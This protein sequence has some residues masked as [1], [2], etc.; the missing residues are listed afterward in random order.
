MTAPLTRQRV[1]FHVELNEVTSEVV[2]ALG[3]LMDLFWYAAV[4]VTAWCIYFA[5]HVG[6]AQL[7]LVRGAGGATILALGLLPA[8]LAS[9]ISWLCLGTQFSSVSTHTL[10][11]V[12]APVCFIGFFGVYALAGLLVV[13]RSITFTI[14]SV[15]DAA[16]STLLRDDE[17][18]KAV[19]FERIYSKRLRELA[20]A[21]FVH[22]ENGQFRI[23]RKGNQILGFFQ[24][25]GSLFKIAAQ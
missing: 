10:A 13:D 25:L 12:T 17:L 7:G 19:P 2:A 8:L 23:T 24:R 6:A 21:G 15:L 18:M 5:V 9:G 11:S 22:A 20:A 1:K 14:L 4:F 16:Q 3:I